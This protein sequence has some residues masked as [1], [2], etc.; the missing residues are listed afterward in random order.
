[1]RATILTHLLVALALTEVHGAAAQEVPRFGSDAQVVVLDV[2]ASDGKGKPV[3][4]LRQDELAVSEDGHLCEILSFRLVRAARAAA[5]PIPTAVRPMGEAGAPEPVGGSAVAQA[6]SPTP[7]RA[8]LV[9]LVFDR[10]T[11]TTAPLARQGALDLVSRDFPAD[12]WFAV[13]KVGYGIRLLAPFTADPARLR[14][15]IEAA[16]A[17]DAQ[18]RTAPLAPGLPPVKVQAEQPPDQPVDPT[19]IPIPDLRPVADALG[20]EEL[21]LA[22]R[23]EGYDSLYAVLGIA[24]ALAAVEGRKSVVYFAEA[25][26]LP[27]AARAVYDDAVSEANRANVAIHTVDVRGLSAHKPI[28]LTLVD[29]VFDRFTADNREGPGPGATTPPIEANGGLKEGGFAL[30][31]GETRETQLSGPTIGRLAEDTG[32]LAIAGTNDLGSG[33]ARVA[34]ELRSYYEVVYA[35]ANPVPDGRFRHIGVTVSRAGVRVRT[36]AGYFATPRRA[37]TLAAYELPLMDALGAATPAHDF[38]LRA[39]ALHFGPKGASRECVLLAEVPLAEVQVAADEAAGAYRAHLTLLGYVKNEAGRVIARLTQDWPIEGPLRERA[40]ARAQSALFR[41]TLP[42]SPGRY[43]LELAVQDRRSGARSVARLPFE[44][45]PA[46]DTLALSSV[47]VLQ[48]VSAAAADSPANDPLRV[49]AVSFVPGLGA[50]FEPGSSPELSLFVGIWPAKRGDPLALTVAFLRD[51]KAVAEATPELPPADADG[52]IAWIGGVPYD[53]LSPGSYEIV[54]TARQGEARVEE[55]TWVVVLARGKADAS[56]PKR[57]PVDPTLAPLLERAAS[58]VVAYQDSF[59]NVVAEEAYTQ[60]AWGLDKSFTNTTAALITFA[61]GSLLQ[62]TRADIVF[63]RLA[64]DFPWGVFRDVFEANGVRV[65]DRD[66]RLEKLFREPSSSAVEQGGK[67]LAESARYNIGPRRTL[68]L[69]TLALLILHPRNQHRF[70]FARG[71]RR[72]FTGV[73]GVEVTFEE[74]ESPS[75]VSD[76]DGG[77]VPSNGRFWI[78]PSRG[79]VLRSEVR[80][81]FEPDRALGFVSTEYRP[82]PRLAM[83]VPAE[84]KERY[85]DVPGTQHPVFFHSAEATARYSNLRQFRVTISEEKATLPPE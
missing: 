9:V 21:A 12:T 74:I 37:P 46:G 15:A 49:G 41:R 48:R 58:Y 76:L 24:R 2:V 13:F 64:G 52:R 33:L 17:G 8:S 42:L 61:D 43:R 75:L 40:R 83:W 3:G 14:S 56:V 25:W 53:R 36:R 50:P 35:P 5:A 85:F 4:D 71:G 78:D 55:R 72:S 54:I 19:R 59:R 47:T 23:V 77:S 18:K 31:G 66:E 79:T 30:R 7:S 26:Q 60:R 45:P 44:V 28:G 20:G 6:P 51:G 80:Y 82:E 1:L 16:T 69:P 22:R 34:E 11:T 68:N 38:T 57:A 67:I 65:R 70:S 32:G 73:E 84:M 27:L 62:R 63:V 39:G 10:L 29:S 81:R